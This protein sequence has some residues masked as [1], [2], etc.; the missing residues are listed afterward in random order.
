MFEY[1]DHEADMGIVGIGSSLEEAF[2]EGAK[3]MFNLM[4]DTDGVE[5]KKTIAIECEA[6]DTESLFVEWLNELLSKKD[7]ENMMFS[8]FKVKSITEVGGIYKLVGKAEG[9]NTDPSKHLLKTEV[10]A[11][12]YSGLK[13]EREGDEFRLQCVVD[14]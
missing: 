7:V 1:I 6:S 12:S 5:P 9:D 4:V 13:F 2:E 10:K 8:V 3:A 11:A 14:L